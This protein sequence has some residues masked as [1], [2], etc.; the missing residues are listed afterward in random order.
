MKHILVDRE[1]KEPFRID[2][3]YMFFENSNK[4][5]GLRVDLNDIPFVLQGDERTFLLELLKQDRGPELVQAVIDGFDAAVE[6]LRLDLER[7]DQSVV[8]G[9]IR[10]AVEKTGRFDQINSFIQGRF[11][12]PNGEA[13][14][15]QEIRESIG[16]TT[17]SLQT[18]V[19]SS[20]VTGASM[21]QGD[22]NEPVPLENLD[23]Q[24]ELL[25]KVLAEIA[26]TKV[27]DDAEKEQKRIPAAARALL[28]LVE[29]F[30]DGDRGL[31]ELRDV[32]TGLASFSE[33][34]ERVMGPTTDYKS[35]MSLRGAL[36]VDPVTAVLLN[37]DDESL[38]R[39]LAAEESASAA[40]R[41]RDV[42]WRVYGEDD[43]K[44]WALIRAL[45][46]FRLG[47]RVELRNAELLRAEFSRQEVQ[48]AF[49]DLLSAIRVSPEAFSETFAD[50]MNSHAMRFSAEQAAALSH[51]LEGKRE[52]LS[53]AVF[54]DI[55]EYPQGRFLGPGRMFNAALVDGEEHLFSAL[56]RLDEQGQVSDVYIGDSITGFYKLPAENSLLSAIAEKVMGNRETIQ[57]A[58]PNDDRLLSGVGPEELRTTLD[59]NPALIRLIA[60]LDNFYFATSPNMMVGDDAESG[61]SY[62]KENGHIYFATSKPAVE[63]LAHEMTHAV[64]EAW[65]ALARD[66]DVEYAEKIQKV[67]EWFGVNHYRLL[68]LILSFS[69]YAAIS[70][71]LAFSGNQET[72]DALFDEALAYLS[73]SVL[74]GEQSTLAELPIVKADIDFLREMGLLPAGDYSRYPDQDFAPRDQKPFAQLFSR[75][76][77]NLMRSYGDT[78]PIEA[79]ALGKDKMSPEREAR[80]INIML[81]LNERLFALAEDTRFGVQHQHMTYGGVSYHFFDVDLGNSKVRIN[82][83]PWISPGTID[84]LIENLRALSNAA[85]WA[86]DDPGVL[87]ANEVIRLAGTTAANLELESQ[88]AAEEENRARTMMRRRGFLGAL[89]GAGVLIAA[90]VTFTPEKQEAPAPPSMPEITTTPQTGWDENITDLIAIRML[91]NQDVTTDG[92]PTETREVL[93][94]SYGV[95]VSEI[96]KAL[97]RVASVQLLST[98]IEGLSQTVGNN[99][100]ALDQ[101]PQGR[102]RVDAMVRK[103]LD[104]YLA[105]L[106]ISALTSGIYGSGLD[107]RMAQQFASV[108]GLSAEERN[109]FETFIRLYRRGQ[110]DVEIVADVNRLLM[111]YGYSFT[112]DFQSNV[113]Y[114]SVLDIPVGTQVGKQKIDQVSLFEKVGVNRADAARGI[115]APG[116]TF[117]SLMR[118]LLKR[119]NERIDNIVHNIPVFEIN[120]DSKEKI[121]K[122]L[123]TIDLDNLLDLQKGLYDADFSALDKQEAFMAI[124]QSVGA[125]ELKHKYDEFNQFMLGQSSM[126]VEASAYIAAISFSKAPRYALEDWLSYA[127]TA[128]I[129]VEDPDLKKVLGHHAKAAWT[130]AEKF[131]SGSESVDKL[132]EWAVDQYTAWGANRGL[133]L[134]GLEGFETVIATFNQNLQTNRAAILAAAASLGTDNDLPG[135][136][137]AVIKLARETA[138]KSGKALTD[139]ELDDIRETA[140]MVMLAHANQ[141]RKDG[142]TPYFTHQIKVTDTLIRIFGIADPVT[143]QITFLHDTREDQ[144]TLYGDI[145]V[146]LAQ[147]IERGDRDAESFG[148][149]RLGVRL[150]TKSE[151]DEETYDRLVHPRKYYN[152]PADG[153][154]VDYGDDFIHRVQLVKLADRI[155][156]LEDLS[157]L[158]R[159]DA[160]FSSDAEADQANALPAITFNKT[161]DLFLPLFVLNADSQLTSGVDGERNLFVKKFETLLDQYSADES[162][163]VLQKAALEARSKLNLF[164]NTNPQY[165][166]LLGR[167]PSDTFL[168]GQEGSVKKA[169]FGDAHAARVAARIVDKFGYTDADREKALAEFVSSRNA[170]APEYRAQILARAE[171]GKGIE[172]LSEGRVESW[173][174]PRRQ[175]VFRDK[176]SPEFP[177]GEPLVIA[178]LQSLEDQITDTL[179]WTVQNFAAKPGN[180]MAV[181]A[182]VRKMIQY[183]ALSPT[184]PM[185]PD[186]ARLVFK[187]MQRMLSRLPDDLRRS[188]LNPPGRPAEQFGAALGDVNF[189]DHPDEFTFLLAAYLFKRGSRNT[190]AQ[191]LG[192][193]HPVLG[194]TEEK[195]DPVL[196]LLYSH[197]TGIK[198]R[199]ALIA[200]VNGF[201]QS[202]DISSRLLDLVAFAERRGR[203][204]QSKADRIMRLLQS[205]TSRQSEIPTPAENV[206]QEDI[207]NLWNSEAGVLNYLNGLRVSPEFRKHYRT[208]MKLGSESAERKL[209]FG[210]DIT[211]GDIVR[212]A[213]FFT[214]LRGGPVANR[215]NLES[216][217]REIELLDDKASPFIAKGEWAQFHAALESFVRSFREAKDVYI[218]QLLLR[219]EQEAVPVTLLPMATLS[220]ASMGSESGA[221]RVYSSQDAL[222]YI[223]QHVFY[224]QNG[225]MIPAENPSSIYDGWV[226]SGVSQAKRGVAAGV[227]KLVDRNGNPELVFVQG[228]GIRDIPEPA[229]E[230]VFS[231]PERLLNN[232]TVEITDQ[233]MRMLR[234]KRYADLFA[235]ASPIKQGDLFKQNGDILIVTRV[236]VETVEQ[237]LRFIYTFKRM[238]AVGQSAAGDSLDEARGEIYGYNITSIEPIA[239]SEAFSLHQ[240]KIAAAVEERRAREVVERERKQKGFERQVAYYEDLAV[241]GKTPS[242]LE[243]VAKL[244]A[245]IERDNFPDLLSRITAALN[246]FQQIAAVSEQFK[247]VSRLTRTIT[248]IDS[249][250]ENAKVLLADAEAQLQSMQRQFDLLPDLPHTRAVRRQ[251]SQSLN[252]SLAELNE[253][254]EQIR[255]AEWRRNEASRGR[256]TAEVAHEKEL[257]SDLNKP[258]TPVLDFQSLNPGESFSYVYEA[259]SAGQPFSGPLVFAMPQD[260]RLIYFRIRKSRT[261]GDFE[262]AQV[263]PVQKDPR[264]HPHLI[265]FR[266]TSKDAVRLQVGSHPIGNRRIDIRTEAGQTRITLTDTG[267]SR[268]TN[269]IV[270]RTT[271][272]AENLDRR[273]DREDWDKVKSIFTIIERSIKERSTRLYEEKTRM[274]LIKSLISTITSWTNLPEDVRGQLL[275]NLIVVRGWEGLLELATGKKLMVNDRQRVEASEWL[276][277][278][279]RVYHHVFYMSMDAVLSKGTKGMILLGEVEQYVPVNWRGFRTITRVKPIFTNMEGG[280]KPGVNEDEVIVLQQQ[281][282]AV[283]VAPELIAIHEAQHQ[284]D[285]I[286]MVQ[287][288][289]QQIG[290][291]VGREDLG[292]IQQALLGYFTIQGWEMEYTAYARTM[293]EIG[294]AIE[295][296]T[297]LAASKSPAEL[298]GDAFAGEKYL[299]YYLKM[300]ESREEHVRGTQEFLRKFLGEAL[301]RFGYQ[302]AGLAV[303]PEDTHASTPEELIRY[304]EVVK[305][306]AMDAQNSGIKSNMGEVGR[307]LRESGQKAL[308]AMY[309]AKLGYVPTYPDVASITPVEV[310]EPASLGGRVSPAALEPGVQPLTFTGTT[311]RFSIGRHSYELNQGRSHSGLTLTSTRTPMTKYAIPFGG[312]KEI[313]EANVRVQY[314]ADRSVQVTALNGEDVVMGQSLGSQAEAE[315]AAV[316][317]LLEELNLEAVVAALEAGDKAEAVRMVREHAQKKLSDIKEQAQKERG[318]L[319]GWFKEFTDVKALADLVYSD[320]FEGQVKAALESRAPVFSEILKDQD[321]FDGL[322]AELK[323]TVTGEA[324]RRLSSLVQEKIGSMTDDERAALQD[325]LAESLKDLETQFKG[326][327][328]VLCINLLDEEKEVIT[329]VL[330]KFSAFFERFVLLG[331]HVSKG[332]FNV[333]FSALPL[334]KNAPD[335]SIQQAKRVAMG[336]LLYLLT[337]GLGLKNPI[338]NA[339]LAEINQI[340]SRQDQALVYETVLMVLIRAGI[341]MPEK[342]W[343]AEELMK[344]AE[345]MPGRFQIGFQRGKDGAF[346]VEVLALVAS[347]IAMAKERAAL[348]KAA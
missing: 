251:I 241:Q 99:L 86:G 172:G 129:N 254:K 224:F 128:Y 341:S 334:S 192:L 287:Y 113:L 230:V 63:T 26:E 48:E 242:F 57:G 159:P 299:D 171:V 344:I 235:K 143:G 205:A 13:R 91:I 21:G 107:T 322:V 256:T 95:N 136:I 40:A 74:A 337:A 41:A 302:R 200:T 281:K 87:N 346:E 8:R 161:I 198:N 244:K 275:V 291:R 347:L 81:E 276:R 176:P 203:D 11:Q 173:G 3:E 56:F 312:N 111:K 231:Y 250:R 266:E 7:D 49:Q 329:Q 37:P 295:T 109:P 16:L 71:S 232:Q 271:A 98:L 237:G 284:F 114:Q 247:L 186:A 110:M 339:L 55:T 118:D 58:S 1:T 145:K 108:L 170:E 265:V 179:Y 196:Q 289:L 258:E 24:L 43:R 297:E 308:D 307:I 138:A 82:A 61:G 321:A 115:S 25:K 125:H 342:D 273:I 105:I 225:L 73:G 272:S 208:L 194:Q 220:G 298:I 294:R 313:P 243:D 182:V 88:K 269:V 97:S 331:G 315:P 212:A 10:K 323:S 137:E 53:R 168:L 195:D 207:R 343:S 68:A 89:L 267:S 42:L 245:E 229:G 5:A 149:I 304:L 320:D 94:R 147:D 126:D 4:P 301:S 257:L 120:E 134:P 274:E 166:E 132:R 65:Q 165:L 178:I 64:F 340:G 52:S 223:D 292:Q 96:D 135:Q 253:K 263:A 75:N 201:A 62:R 70:D 100:N 305:R 283:D 217:F 277:R 202:P 215:G 213:G 288:G 44:L 218:Q 130:A 317:F 296:G 181:L 164:L 106:E 36:Q 191:I 12:K 282:G 14:S 260:G 72:Q 279:F 180:G 222:D 167:K 18:A 46:Q 286:E 239:R 290:A 101:I 197:N 79:A 6:K 193:D 326:K 187:A 338:P 124:V 336:P 139:K 20:E 211:F 335:R 318:E 77:R 156:N 333:P 210:R 234:E 140:R 112:F 328:F 34:Y 84:L 38:L 264:L 142:K 240:A 227:I 92:T 117:V 238:A 262:L 246:S 311:I 153:Y 59:A 15:N 184:G 280:F 60:G 17:Q 151:T 268:G 47:Q 69:A 141:T 122:E 209:V 116:D 121:Q 152:K 177:D 33:R 32:L 278:F 80:L 127:L 319:M 330:A 233:H 236:Q 199:E 50:F 285:V 66:N 174:L 221:K 162:M 54:Q 190:V 154:Y 332:D 325:I 327:K 314:G 2:W 214:Q 76:R 22:R 144:E 30:E 310:V 293:V 35:L 206:T 185:S 183:G 103:I 270:N 189:Q 259:P 175:I 93:A 309:I 348:A 131:K 123:V 188:L 90:G 345:E 83:R 252:L 45:A 28:Q 148:Y 228:K 39:P 29:I 303:K 204:E 226:V 9:I 249:S 306:Y 19:Q 23:G 219:V 158:F 146:F 104:P 324:V 163:P 31:E 300:G 157:N 85:R 155:V 133:N 261:R 67:R 102:A 160:V 27:P 78:A 119:Q 150:L 316:E 248:D 216:L 51:A 255:K 169:G